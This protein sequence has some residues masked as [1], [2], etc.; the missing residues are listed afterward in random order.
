MEN[1]RND[2]CIIL[3]GYPQQMQRLWDYDPG[4]K[5]RFTEFIDFP[6]YNASELLAIFKQQMN[7]ESCYS[8]N[9]EDDDF[10]LSIFEKL[11]QI[12]YFANARTLRKLIDEL[13]NIAVMSAVSNQ[14]E[15]SF[16]KEYFDIALG[17]LNG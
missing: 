16:Q 14:R 12:R 3:A 6:D 17:R 1:H 8:L 7:K 13:K 4:L 10:L 15:I 2:I 5:G 11:R 9:F